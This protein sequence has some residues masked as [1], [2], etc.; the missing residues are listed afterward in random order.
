MKT[1]LKNC[2]CCG[3][4]AYISS[5]KLAPYV[6]KHGVSCH[7]CGMTTPFFWNEK[8][9]INIWNRRYSE[10]EINHVAYST[11]QMGRDK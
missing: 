6:F 2:P 5:K 11:E 4:A 8:E 7:N 10:E 1:D 3:G 9:A